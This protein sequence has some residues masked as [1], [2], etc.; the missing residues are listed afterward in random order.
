ML[1]S[2]AETSVIKVYVD[3]PQRA[4]IRGAHTF[5][6]EQ[7]AC[8]KRSLS[9]DKEHRQELVPDVITPH[10]S[11]GSWVCHYQVVQMLDRH[12]V[13]RIASER[14]LLAVPLC[15]QMH[16]TNAALVLDMLVLSHSRSAAQ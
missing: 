6:Q 15:H 12:K 14:W 13:Q 11:N 5:Q 10:N 3:N 1:I 4:T 8:R 2:Q 9:V 16:H 7:A